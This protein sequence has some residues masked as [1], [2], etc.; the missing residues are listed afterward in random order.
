MAHDF[1]HTP[2]A[3]TFLQRL[4]GLVGEKRK[5]RLFLLIP[6]CGSVHTFFMRRPIDVVFLDAASHVVSIVTD[7]RPWRVYVGPP[8]TRHVLELPAGHARAT[9]IQETDAVAIAL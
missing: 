7:A 3:R 2:V 5:E 6:L 8:A 1:T 4:V 9:G